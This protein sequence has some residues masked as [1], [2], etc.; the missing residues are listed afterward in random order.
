[1]D[2]LGVILTTIWGDLGDWEDL[3][4]QGWECFCVPVLQQ[5]TTKDEQVRM[6]LNAG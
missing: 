6:R 4:S 3:K 2:L 5:L 1:L